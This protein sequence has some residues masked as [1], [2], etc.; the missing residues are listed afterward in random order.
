MQQLVGCQRRPDGKHQTAEI[1]ELAQLRARL[2]EREVFFLRLVGEQH[3]DD[4]ALHRA[5]QLV[6]SWRTLARLA[7]HTRHALG[8]QSQHAAAVGHLEVLGNRALPLGDR[9]L[10]HLDHAQVA[11]HALGER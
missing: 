2:A 9:A 1:T 6:V 11:L 4:L 3:G 5:A 7:H 10:E 8:L